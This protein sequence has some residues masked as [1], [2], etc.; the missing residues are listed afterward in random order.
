MNKRSFLIAYVNA[1]LK[2]KIAFTRF[3]KEFQNGNQNTVRNSTAV[4]QNNNAQGNVPVQ[5]KYGG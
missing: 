3:E 1:E 2:A 5:P 4:R